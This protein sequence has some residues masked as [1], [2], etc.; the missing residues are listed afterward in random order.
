MDDGKL[1]WPKLREYLLRVSS[2]QSN[3]EFM[4][5]A[6]LEVQ[7]LIPFDITA[8]IFSVLDSGFLG[9]TGA[10]DAATS[11][12]SYYRDRLPSFGR[13]R[14]Y[15]PE[16]VDWRGMGSF[17]FALDFMWPNKCWKSLNHHLFPGQQVF[18][19]YSGLG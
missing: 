18:L 11:F 3:Q 1:P 15:V 16:I 17:E 9:G 6:C 14:S 5:T 7:A 10:S 8:N 13:D 2:C 19:R 4:R 12:N